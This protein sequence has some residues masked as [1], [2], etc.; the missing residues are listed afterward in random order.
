M[1]K[2]NYSD[3]LKYNNHLEY[4]CSLFCDEESRK[5]IL[6]VKSLQTEL[7]QIK[8]STSETTIALIKLKW[9]EDHI[10]DI[11][12]SK[13]KTKHHLL[14]NL[15]D[16]INKHDLEKNL[17]SQIFDEY[18]RSISNNKFATKDEL[19]KH[20]ILLYGN[21]HHIFC[22]IIEE[23]YSID[24]INNFAIAYGIINNIKEHLYFNQELINISGTS[25]KEII[26]LAYKKINLV[27]LPESKKL[28][29]IFLPKNIIRSHIN[30]IKKNNYSLKNIELSYSKLYLLL[31]CIYNYYFK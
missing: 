19:E 29:F 25:F 6:V 31:S 27:K 16:I 20:F 10:N 3:Y 12:H 15:S 8:Y 30:Q 24:A 18:S 9:W 14:L 28:K 22:K 11:Y 4:L 23:K 2:I 26:N 1:T 21:F 5:T 7:N 13:L 17:F